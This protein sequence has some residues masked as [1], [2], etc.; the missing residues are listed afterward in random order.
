MQCPLCEC[1]VTTNNTELLPGYKYG[2]VINGILYC[3]ECS[4]VA[5]FAEDMSKTNKI[6]TD[7]PT[8]TKKEEIRT[9]NIIHFYCSTCKI[10]ASGSA[11]NKCG[12]Q[13]PLYKKRKK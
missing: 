12:K 6:V 8:E 3:C 13:N 11:C 4:D 10:Q 7:K 5:F 2:S 9:T 1:N